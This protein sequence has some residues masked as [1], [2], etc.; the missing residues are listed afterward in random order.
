M[1]P[2]K[3]LDKR[4]ISHDARRPKAERRNYIHVN[5]VLAARSKNPIGHLAL[6]TILTQHPG[7]QNDARMFHKMV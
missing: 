1:I 7:K 5:G 4:Q 2:Q 6:R 3:F